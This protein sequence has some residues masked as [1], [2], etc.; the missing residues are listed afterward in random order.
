MRLKTWLPAF[1]IYLTAVVVAGFFN[2]DKIFLWTEDRIEERHSSTV[3]R[4]LR[5]VREFYRASPAAPL[6]A[7]ADR[8]LAP[9][10]HD[11]YKSTP[12]SDE[13]LDEAGTQ[14]AGAKGED[15][16]QA[17]LKPTVTD[18]RPMGREELLAALDEA[19]KRAAPDSVEAD[20]PADPAVPGEPQAA[21][22]KPAPSLSDTFLTRR[23][24]E[25]PH[26]ILV[27]GDSLAIGLSLSLRRSVNEYEEITLI[28]EGKVSSGLA[29]PKYFN[30]EKALRTFVDKYSPSMV[31]VMMGAN[32]AKYI[33]LNEKPR[34]PGSPN[35]TWGEVFAMRLEAFLD[36]P[37]KRDLP[38]FWI[39]LPVMGDPTYAR[40]AQAMN[41]IVRTECEK[42]PNCRF[43]E[44]WD[45][46]C[47]PEDT[48][49][50][51]LK[52]DKG[53]K[54]KI[55]ANDKIHFTAAGGDILA[56]SF[57]DQASRLA[58]FRP[59]PEKTAE[60]AAGEASPAT[61]ATP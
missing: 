7:D 40:Q 22:A 25:P 32:D 60:T 24:L 9:F 29:N 14:A 4:G 31:V 26:R 17:V 47:D 52:N 39:G 20:M 23:L 42:Y 33:N 44:T 28:E 51:F 53:V 35:K 6:I 43:L 19:E 61:T 16:Y 3:L 18:L 50:A 48:Y 45:L 30:W 49:A 5:A 15:P 54:I 58:V 8:A 59:R 38:V 27:V 56:R 55:R 41:D 10:F 36:I 11:T 21:S 57:F 2:I 46:L 1:C 34:E 13:T 12:A 37:A